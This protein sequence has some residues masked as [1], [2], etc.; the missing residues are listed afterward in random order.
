MVNGNLELALLLIKPDGFSKMDE[1]LTM[2]N[3]IGCPISHPMIYMPGSVP[4]NKVREFVSNHGKEDAH[5]SNLADLLFEYLAP[6]PLYT[7]V[8]EG[9]DLYRLGREII[10]HK[11][12]AEARRVQEETGRKNVR[13]MSE[14][15]F[16]I[17]NSQG[18]AV[19][20]IA[21]LSDGL[22]AARREIEIW[23]PEVKDFYPGFQRLETVE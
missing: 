11:N 2:L 20:N 4:P 9:E 10:G 14:D 3:Q 1:I 6:G 5:G 21:H 23:H 17:A 12:P 8:Y 15:S 16:E 7:V 13:A 18:R 19:Y 22:F